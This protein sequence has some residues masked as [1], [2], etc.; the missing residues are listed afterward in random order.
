MYSRKR[1]DSSEEIEDESEIHMGFY[2]FS[3][4]IGTYGKKL[5]IGAE[6]GLEPIMRRRQ[7]LEVINMSRNETE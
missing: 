2:V 3:V 4:I 7:E 6:K 1:Y 5:L